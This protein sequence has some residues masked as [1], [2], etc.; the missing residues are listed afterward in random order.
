MSSAAF[1][2]AIDEIGPHDHAC[3]IYRSTEQRL[4][5]AV[6]YFRQGLLKNDRCVYVADE[7]TAEGALE[8][9]R[10]HGI[11][12]AVAAARGQL[13]VMPSQGAYLVDGRFDAERMVGFLDVAT[14]Q[15][16]A[17][18]FDALRVTGE[19]SW[20]LTGNVPIDD[21]MRY[22]QRLNEYGRDHCISGI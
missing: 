11:A 14:N 6:P 20:V 17:D 8:N 7:D 5:S 3:L 22:E 15:A 21:L 18:G 19:M 2:R 12:T 4:A 10:S 9:L 1:V 16:L 13:V